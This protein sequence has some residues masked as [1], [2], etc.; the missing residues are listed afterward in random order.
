MPIVIPTTRAALV[1]L[2]AAARAVPVATEG[3][4]GVEMTVGRDAEGG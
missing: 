1:L 2:E 4:L 3:L